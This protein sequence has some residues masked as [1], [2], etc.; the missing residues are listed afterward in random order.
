MVAIPAKHKKNVPIASAKSLLVVFIF[1]SGF[2]FGDDY[3]QPI[4]SECRFVDNRGSHP[5]ACDGI[6][7][8]RHSIL[9]LESPI[10]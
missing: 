9:E 3:K 7:G 8:G 6:A 1:P 4:V 10:Y 2:D 5:L